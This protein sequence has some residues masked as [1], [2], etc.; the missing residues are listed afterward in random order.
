MAKR[1]TSYVFLLFEFFASL[2]LA[3][4]LILALAVTL[5][6]GTVYESKYGAVVASREVYRGLWMQ[7]LLWI[8]M[9]NQ[10]GRAHV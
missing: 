7:F 8:F 1:L 2:E 10:I 9:I 3:V 5:A 4:F 6:V